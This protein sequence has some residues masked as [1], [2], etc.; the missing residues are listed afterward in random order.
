MK[1][2]NVS[3]FLLSVFVWFLFCSWQSNAY[4]RTIFRKSSKLNCSAYRFACRDGSKCVYHRHRCDGERDC[5]DGSD[6]DP[7]ICGRFFKIEKN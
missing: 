4:N 7:M 2:K 6:E 5:L 3:C 1:Q